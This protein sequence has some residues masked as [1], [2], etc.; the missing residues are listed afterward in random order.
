MKALALVVSLVSSLAFADGGVA[1]VRAR[2]PRLDARKRGPLAPGI[3]PMLEAL[4]PAALPELISAVG[5]PRDPSWTDSA[6]LA[7]QASVVEALG[8]LHDVQARPVFLKVLS[9]ESQPY[10]VQRAA[11]EGLAKLGDVEALA[12]LIGRD[13]VVGGIGSL[14]KPVTVQL[15]AAELEKHPPLARAKLIVSALSDV[16][17]AWAWK[18]LRVRDEEM[19]TR[20][21]AARVLVQAFVAYDAD[22]RQAASNALMVVDA[23]ASP[24]LIAEA[25]AVRGMPELETLALRVAKNP[26]R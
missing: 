8:S 21:E 9:D 11:A 20:N 4:G 19:T 2:V 14:R 13:A 6:V 12:P 18:T 5:E 10:L 23:P 7:W 22:V 1:A 3:R 16:G 17:N 24:A 25:R 15:L 26:L